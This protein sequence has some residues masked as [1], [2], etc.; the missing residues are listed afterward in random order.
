MEYSGPIS[1]QLYTTIQ[2]EFR[3]LSVYFSRKLYLPV[4]C[5]NEMK[6]SKS[7]L[8]YQLFHVKYVHFGRHLETTITRHT[9]VTDP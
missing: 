1:L 2:Y 7:A 8:Y 5:D 3:T 9:I 4:A 6:I